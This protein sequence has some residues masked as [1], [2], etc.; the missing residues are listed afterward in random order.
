MVGS[1]APLW[2]TYHST[3]RASLFVRILRIWGRCTAPPRPIPPRPGP[4]AP[5]PPAVGGPAGPGVPQRWDREGA[6]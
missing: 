5:R 2:C 4:A 3:P 6:D 1:A